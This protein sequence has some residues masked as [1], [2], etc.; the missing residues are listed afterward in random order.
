MEFS[1]ENSIEMWFWD[2][3]ITHKK[4]NQIWKDYFFSYF[5]EGVPK[6]PIISTIWWMKVTWLWIEVGERGDFLDWNF[7]FLFE[8]RSELSIL[9][10]ISSVFPHS[11][12]SGK[13][14]KC[15]GYANESMIMITNITTTKTITHFSSDLSRPMWVLFLLLAPMIRC[16]QKSL[17]SLWDGPCSLARG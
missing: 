4:D 8:P 2:N 1:A 10:I 3:S 13:I 7:N 14:H 12:M 11:G 15:H 17:Y 9:G 16:C 6:I 5:I